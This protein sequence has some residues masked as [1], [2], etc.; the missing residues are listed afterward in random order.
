M[1]AVLLRLQQDP[2]H[3]KMYWTTVAAKKIREMIR[4]G[5]QSISLP[6]RPKESL[7]KNH[8][9]AREVMFRILIN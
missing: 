2:R 3:G 8:N 9:A 7:D 4:N 6:D 5:N 1:T